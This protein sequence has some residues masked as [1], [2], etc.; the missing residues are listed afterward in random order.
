MAASSHFLVLL[1]NLSQI[2]YSNGRATGLSRLETLPSSLLRRISLLLD[3]EV[4][5]VCLSLTSKVLAASMRQ[6][7][8]RPHRC[9]GCGGCHSEDDEYDDR[10]YSWF[11]LAM[12]IEDS[13]PESIQFCHHCLVFLPKSSFATA[14]PLTASDTS[15]GRDALAC[16]D[17]L[18]LT[19]P[20]VQ[21]D[22][23]DCDGCEILQHLLDDKD[24]NEVHDEGNA[25]SP[26]HVSAS[27]MSKIGDVSHKPSLPNAGAACLCM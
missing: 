17:C 7:W 8:A 6:L 3:N 5:Q 19:D 13:M 21:Y 16:F 23:E 20:R 25:C 11:D 18:R 24:D 12:R 22:D 2:V 9:P 10:T 27:S 1:T 26:K 4:D 15:V 14:Y